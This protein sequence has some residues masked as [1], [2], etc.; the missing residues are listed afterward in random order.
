[1]TVDPVTTVLVRTG[2][3][4]ICPALIWTGTEYA[5]SPYSLLA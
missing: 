4:G 3:S 1:V 5:L 2:L